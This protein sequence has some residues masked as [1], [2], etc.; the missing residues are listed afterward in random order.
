[1]ARRLILLLALGVTGTLHAQGAQL[2]DFRSS[3]YLFVSA[4]EDARA[5]WLNPAGLAA[6][7]E[8]SVH[9]ELALS[10]PGN[11]GFHVGQWTVGFNSRGLALGYARDRQPGSGSLHAFRLGLAV[12]ERGNGLG[13]AVTLYGSDDETHRGVDL[14]ARYRLLAGL[15]AGAV[16]QN[17]GRPIVRGTPLPIT[18]TAGLA[19]TLAQ[20]HVQLGG[21]ARAI[22]REAPQSGYDVSYRAGARLSTVGRLPV[23]GLVA[24]DL[25]SNLRVDRWT[26][27]IAVGGPD[28]LVL[29][30]SVVP[31]V[32]GTQHLQTMSLAGV[33]TRIRPGRR[34]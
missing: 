7:P 15:Q 13:A 34:F 25:G 2:V 8:A 19:W 9:G 20:S 3:D 6:R 21:E 28:R 16:V 17:I 5:L 29:A 31:L 30:G 32:G 4:V 10:R 14:G 12:G 26:I 18:G 11:Q 27:G 24:L 33:A 1:M 23:A 22:E